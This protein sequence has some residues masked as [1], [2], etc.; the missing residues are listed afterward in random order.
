MALLERGRSDRAALPDEVDDP[1]AWRIVAGVRA[2]RCRAGARRGRR[3]VPAGDRTLT[4]VLRG[5]A[6]PRRGPARADRVRRRRRR[7]RWSAAAGRGGRAGR[8][9]PRRTGCAPRCWPRSAT[10]CARRWPRPRPSVEPRCARRRRSG[11]RGGPAELLAG[12]EESL[13]RLDRAGGEPAG[14][15]PP[16]GRRAEPAHGGRRG[17]GRRG[18]GAGRPGHRAGRR[19]RSGD[20]PGAAGRCAADPVLLERAVANLVANALQVQPAGAGRCSPARSELGGRVELRV[21]D[22]GR[23]SPED[24]ERVFVPFQRLG[25]RDNAT[26]VGPGPGPVPGAR[27]GDGRHAVARGDA[28]RGPDDGAYRCRRRA[29]PTRRPR[30]CRGHRRGPHRPR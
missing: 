22:R 7:S 16:A 18:D 9:W 30:R 11:R 29:S 12:A 5:R 8:R 17:R 4:L 27:G 24:R 13:D 23:G 19:W 1:D 20:L 6:L 3:E 10:T 25:D 26:G 15:E 2:A 21:T 28:R 14:H